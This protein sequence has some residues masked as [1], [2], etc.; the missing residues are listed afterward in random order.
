MSSRISRLGTIC[1]ILYLLVFL[2]ALGFAIIM[3]EDSPLAAIHILILTFPWS[4]IFTILLFVV[5]LNDSISINVS[6]M[7]FLFYA[8]GNASIIY[9][10][11]SKYEQRKNRQ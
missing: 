6:L 10:L 9:Y 8:I 1:G 7:M 3:I 11:F 4:Y 5:G 2:I